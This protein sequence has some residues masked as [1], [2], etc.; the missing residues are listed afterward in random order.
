MSQ[1]SQL[2]GIVVSVVDARGPHPMMWFP[3][4]F[5]TISQI[6]NA[7]VKSFAI[8]IGDKTYRDKS[9]SDL[10]CFGLL[11]YQDMD[12]IGFIY[13]SGFEDPIER[14]PLPKQRPATIT[15]L[16][17]KSYRDEVCHKSPQI[18]NL[19]DREANTLW[20]SLQKGE[21]NAKLLSELYNKLIAF[22]EIK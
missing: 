5:G 18:H 3:K 9:P 10:T 2:T 11:P 8:M 17:K 4:D 21:T 22:L 16:F 13:F 12:S 15:L 19:L 20:E 7:A 6:H 14:K 1:E